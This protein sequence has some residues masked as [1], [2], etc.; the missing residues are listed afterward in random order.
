MVTRKS[1]TTNK[2]ELLRIVVKLKQFHKILLVNK[3]V[4][5]NNRKDITH[6][7]MEYHCEHV[8]HQIIL[9]KYYGAEIKCIKGKNN[10]V[11]GALSRL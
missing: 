11:T 3:I 5:Y 8:M 4:V 10:E 2:K 1:F 7:Y 6:K 9:I